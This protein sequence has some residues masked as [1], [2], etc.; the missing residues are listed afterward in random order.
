MTD[1]TIERNFVQHYVTPFINPL[2]LCFGV[3]ANYVA[4][5]ICCCAGENWSIASSF[6]FLHFALMMSRGAARTDFAWSGRFTR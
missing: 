1:P 3:Y 5:T 6:G 2:L 4:H